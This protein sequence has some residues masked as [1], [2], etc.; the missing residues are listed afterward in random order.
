[1]REETVTERLWKVISLKN[2]VIENLNIQIRHMEAQEKI[3]QTIIDNFLK[4][5]GENK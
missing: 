5:E 1:M 2:A 4:T 3:T